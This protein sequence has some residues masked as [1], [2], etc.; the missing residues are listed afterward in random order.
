M[1]APQNFRSAFNGFNREDVVNYISYISTRHETA[2]NELRSE[3]EELRAQLAEQDQA[4]ADCDGLRQELEHVIA[5]KAT[6]KEVQKN[7]EAQ[8][9]RLQEVLQAKEQE[10]TE[11]S[12]EIQRLNGMLEQCNEEL[13]SLRGEMELNRTSSAAFGREEKMGR[14]A[15]ELNAYRRAESCER[16][17]RERVNQMYDQANGALAEASVRVEQTTGQI[18]QLAAKVESDVAMLLKAMA[19]GETAFADTAMMLGAIRPETD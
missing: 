7:L 1:D 18:S 9:A 6:A 5:E 2:L 16:R 14:W 4:A 10:L 8:L 12:A 3:A 11:Q 15:E 17:A 19:E 13:D